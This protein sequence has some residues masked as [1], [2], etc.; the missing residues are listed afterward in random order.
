MSVPVVWVSN[1]P[2]KIISRGYYDQTFLEDL[3]SGT[4]ELYRP[5][6][7]PDFHHV[8]GFGPLVFREPVAVVVV[9]ARWH[10]SAEDVEWLNTNLGQIDRVLVILTGDEASEFDLTQLE[11]L[12]MR[13][14]VQ[15]PTAHIATLARPV[16]ELYTPGLRATVKD[17]GAG[18]DTRPLDWVFAGQVNNIRRKECVA[19]LRD[20]PNGFL[21][22]TDCFLCGLPPVEYAEKLTEARV[23]ACPSGIFTPSTF[24]VFEALEAGAVPIVDAK[25]PKGTN[26]YWAALFGTDHPVPVIEEWSDFP[27]MMQAVIDDWP[28]STNRVQ[29][30]YQ[31]HKR[32]LACHLVDDLTALGTPRPV[33]LRDRITVLLPTSPIPS[34]PSTQIIEETIASV[35]AYPELGE[36]EIIIMLDGVR[37]EQEHRRADYE[38]YTR[39]VLWLS[40]HE[41]R[42]VLPVRFDDFQHQANMTRRALE[43]VRTELV[44]FVEHDTPL[45]GEI[46]WERFTQV[47]ASRYCKL[48]RLYHEGVMPD[49]HR[50]L[51]VSRPRIVNG[52]RL[53]KTRQWSQRPHLATTTL[54]RHLMS[55]FF[56][57]AER[58]MIEDVLHSSLEVAFHTRAIQGWAEFGTAIYTP[59]GLMQRSLHA[60]G[61]QGDEKF[62]M[63]LQPRDDAGIVKHD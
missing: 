54:Y 44:L 59:D 55:K 63:L 23:V 46:P 33:A 8:E 15:T 4:G 7:L 12:A 6:G 29:A 52:V 1:H 20:L 21:H 22:T 62:E 57:P 30:W 61:R 32:G 18:D 48:I 9:P 40:N 13:V 42:N 35:R 26:G 45:V 5:A 25:A 36:C 17:L 56:H 2:G 41:W 47:I 10:A 49:V 51:M 27:K 43:L 28:A 53:T 58:T 38:E 11:H 37:P 39:R 31:G 14:W 24:R 34:H 16:G 50:P 60:D 3:F 19:V